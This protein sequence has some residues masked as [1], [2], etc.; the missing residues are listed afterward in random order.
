MML[1]RMTPFLVAIFAA[2]T[3]AAESAGTAKPAGVPAAATPADNPAAAKPADPPVAAKPDDHAAAAKSPATPAGAK[4]VAKPVPGRAAA[5]RAAGQLPPGLPRAHYKYRTTVAPGAA[6]L[7]LRRGRTVVVEEESIDLPLISGGIEPYAPR[8]FGT[9]LLP[10]SSTL[11]GY[12]GTSHSYSYDGPYYG[13]PSFWN[14]LPY[15]CGV[16]GY[17]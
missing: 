9:P 14:R 15:A 5:V 11:P 8:I 6:P 1:R 2:G 16:Y 7:Y 10:G 17:C 4:R 12:Y 13:S 3:A